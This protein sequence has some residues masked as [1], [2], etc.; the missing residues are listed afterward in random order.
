[1]DWFQLVQHS[2]LLHRARS[3]AAVPR[4]PMLAQH[5]M[6]QARVVFLIVLVVF[7][8]ALFIGSYIWMRQPTFGQVGGRRA[9]VPA[10]EG[11]SSEGPG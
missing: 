9:G 3:A 5:P 1:M 11:R 8:C 2:D 7:F 4:V 10:S 6:S